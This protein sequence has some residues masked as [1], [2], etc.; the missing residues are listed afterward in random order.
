MSGIHDM[1]KPGNNIQKY[2]RLKTGKIRALQIL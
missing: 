1:G 2:K